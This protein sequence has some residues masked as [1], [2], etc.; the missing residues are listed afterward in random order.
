VALVAAVNKAYQDET[1]FDVGLLE[2]LNAYLDAGG[3]VEKVYKV[4]D[5]ACTILLK[6][7]WQADDGAT[8]YAMGFSRQVISA[9]LGIR[10]YV[11][12]LPNY[13]ITSLLFISSSLLPEQ[14]WAS[15]YK[16]FRD[17]RNAFDNTITK[18]G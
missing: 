16:A 3:V 14:A 2:A 10:N 1:V 12:T 18:F 6:G 11:F 17:E 4:G 9:M 8:T 5:K 13:T 7:E 15:L